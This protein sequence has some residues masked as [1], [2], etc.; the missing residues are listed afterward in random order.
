MSRRWDSFS[1]V[2]IA[3]RT[4]SGAATGGIRCGEYIDG[5]LI[6]RCTGLGTGGKVTGY[7]QRSADG[8]TWGDLERGATMTATGTKII[9]LSGGIGNFAR[10]RWVIATGAKF[11]MTFTFK[12]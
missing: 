12:E 6:I 9:A 8:S 10:G 11:S 7:W 2:G 4:S 1:H 3:T 5:Q